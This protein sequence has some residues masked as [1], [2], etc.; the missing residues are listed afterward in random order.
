MSQ[1]TYSVSEL[2]QSIKSNLEV[3]PTFKSFWLKGEVSNYT[4]HHSGHW[5]FTLKDKNAR[6]SCIMFA[7]STTSVHFRVKEGDKVLVKASVTLYPPQG[8]LQIN[9]TQMSLDGVGDLFLQFEKL[10][11]KLFDEGLFDAARKKIIPKYPEDIGIITGAKTAALQDVLKTLNL[12]WPG[13]KTRVYESLV[14]GENAVNQLISQ[15]L[16][17]DQNGHDVLILARGGG[18]I[19][20]LWAFNDERLVRLITQLTTPLVSGIGHEVD[21]TIT[22]YVADLRAATPTAAAQAVIRDFREVLTETT[23]IRSLLNKL[24]TQRLNQSKLNFSR[25]YQYPIWMNPEMLI[26]DKAIHLTMMTQGLFQ[27]AST[28]KPHEN[29]LNALNEALR[30]ATIQ[31]IRNKENALTSL[32]HDIISSFKTSKQTK[33]ALFSQSIGLLNAYSP[34]AVIKR[35]YSIASKNGHVI[36]TIENVSINDSITIRVNDGEI[37][38]VVS[39]KESYGKEKL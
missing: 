8:S 9:V 29:R 22:D 17:A 21:V 36:K 10:K 3:N 33:F 27:Y 32:K 12:R 23:Q 18:S 19:E 38:S 24:I 2:L 14:Q 5:Y 30:F 13:I 35:G 37:Q 39:Q 20:D 1:S 34:L 25:L 16:L 7:Q 31:S 15:L 26:Q 4:A 6:I 11:K 28:M